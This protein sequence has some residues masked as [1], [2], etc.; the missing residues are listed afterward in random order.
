MCFKLKSVSRLPVDMYTCVLYRYT[1]IHV[2]CFGGA[3]QVPGT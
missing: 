1:D 3:R 2:C